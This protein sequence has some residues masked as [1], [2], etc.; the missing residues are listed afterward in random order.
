MIVFYA[1]FGNP[2][3]DKRYSAAFKTQRRQR[4]Q[5]SRWNAEQGEYNAS[6]LS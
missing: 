1:F 6:N 3:Y 4:R 5:H 2:Q